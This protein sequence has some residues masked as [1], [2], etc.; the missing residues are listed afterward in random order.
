MNMNNR[1]SLNP[2]WQFFWEEAVLTGDPLSDPNEFKLFV[3]EKRQSKAPITHTLPALKFLGQ[4]EMLE[5]H[6]ILIQ[7][8]YDRVMDNNMRS[9]LLDSVKAN[10]DLLAALLSSKLEKRI[11]MNQLSNYDLSTKWN[12][13]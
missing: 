13:S 3:R 7:K 8:F 9:N 6:S 12:I 5:N 4:Y 1:I 10:R 2:T 11:Y